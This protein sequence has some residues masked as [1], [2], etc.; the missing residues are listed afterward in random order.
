MDN[1]ERNRNL[2]KNKLKT[3]G[4]CLLFFIIW[5]VLVVI[6]ERF[7]KPYILVD[8]IGKSDGVMNIYNEIVHLFATIIATCI[9]I[10]IVDRKKQMKL[11][12][13]DTIGIDS[14]IGLGLGLGYSALTVAILYF[15]KSVSFD[16][17]NGSFSLGLIIWI[18]ALFLHSIMIHLLVRG[19]VYKVIEREQSEL[20][21]II[22]TGIIYMLVH[23][24][25]YHSDI[26]TI[27]NI[28]TLGLIFSFTLS[29]FKSLWSVII[30]DFSYSIVLG[31]GTGF[32]KLTSNYPVCIS[33]SVSNHKLFSF[34]TYGLLSGI[35]ITII[36]LSLII[37]LMLLK[38]KNNSSRKG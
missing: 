18:F 35:L 29:I 8:F 21:G 36:N 25:Y 38:I 16:I 32:I 9:L 19:Y 17:K 37:F 11:F 15:I 23:L 26:L 14:L 34:G 10:F 1:M 33:S 24:K 3:L 28:L 4:K 27:F 6:T 20:S 2:M 31:L 30:M 13:F 7:F 22:I 12:K 5:I